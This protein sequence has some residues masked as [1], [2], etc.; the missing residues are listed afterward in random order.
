MN[1]D[2]PVKVKCKSKSTELCA[3]KV[4]PPIVK[5]LTFWHF[6]YKIA[7]FHSHLCSGFDIQH[8][9]V[10][11][12]ETGQERYSWQ[13]GKYTWLYSDVGQNIARHA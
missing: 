4:G 10:Y 13:R 11:R 2:G 7:L 9:R 5:L 6:M 1:L 8:K 12:R 3:N